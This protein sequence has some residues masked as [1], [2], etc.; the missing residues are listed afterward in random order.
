MICQG[1]TTLV[2]NSLSDKDNDYFSKACFS[3]D[4]TFHVSGTVNRH[5]CRIWGSEN[6]HVAREYERDTPKL[7]VWCGL[8]SA[9]V[10]GR[11]FF[12]EIDRDRCCVPWHTWELLYATGIWCVHLPAWR[13]TSPLLDTSH[14][15]PQSVFRRKVDRSRW[16]HSMAPSITGFDTSWLLF[17]R[18]RQRYCLPHQ[19][20]WLAWFAL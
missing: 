13:G 1:T 12:H 20:Q 2:L 16:P 8:T 3:D 18:I 7:N 11:F 15:I 10:I 19:R 4:A 9:G 17:V 14:Q 5:N 6:L